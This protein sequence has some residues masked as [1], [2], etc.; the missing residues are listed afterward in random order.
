MPR[1]PEGQSSHPGVGPGRDQPTCS[2]EQGAW[3][4]YSEG[5]DKTRGQEVGGAV[6]TQPERP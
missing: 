6:A 1:L 2:P 3:L 5:R 4:G